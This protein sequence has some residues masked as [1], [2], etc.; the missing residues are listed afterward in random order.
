MDYTQKIKAICPRQILSSRGYPTVEVDIV[1]DQDE[2]FRS[3]AP[4]GDSTGAK[5]VA[6]LTDKKDSYGGRSVTGVIKKF[7]EEIVPLIFKSR[8]STQ[9]EFDSVLYIADKTPTLSTYGANT[10]L[11]LSLSFCK[12]QARTD[13]L[14]VHD[15][16]AKISKNEPHMPVPNFNIL[17]GGSHS[18]NELLF[19]EIM[20]SFQK[21]TFEKNLES[22]AVF[23]AALKNTIRDKFGGI[24]TGFGDEGGFMP[25]IRTLEDG[26]DLIREVLHKTKQEG[27]RIAIDAAANS[28]FAGGKYTV[29]TKDRDVELSGDELID[30]YRTL[31]KTYPEIY[32]MEDPFAETDVEAWKKFTAEFGS[33]LIILGDDLL[34]TNSKMIKQAAEKKLCNA[35]LIKP[36]QIGTLGGTLEAVQAARE[37]NFKVMVSHRSGETED[38][39]IAALSVGVAAEF[40]K[41]GAPRGE[42]MVKYNQLL[43]IEEELERDKSK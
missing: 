19:Q 16:I 8:I 4:S 17:N 13:G 3:S 41:S 5:E 28:F 22:A 31:L 14:R 6:V 35:V 42:R 40:F 20:I 12:L 32:L 30:Y 1:S 29:R 18:G 36:N 10:L 7:E 23:Y 15:H 43:R 27:L 25:P 9:M 2:V 11:P 33:S 37:N 24:Y 26:L 39:F 34:V 21:N 38:P